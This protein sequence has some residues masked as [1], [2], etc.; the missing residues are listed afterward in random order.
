MNW[1][2][3]DEL[4]SMIDH[5]KHISRHLINDINDSYE[6]FFESCRD[7]ADNISSNIQTYSYTNI[8]PYKSY[9]SGSTLHI[10]EQLIFSLSQV[11]VTKHYKNKLFAEFNQF[12]NIHSLP[13]LLT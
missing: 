12:T 5:I 8:P 1:L 4:V 2:V 9:K 7:Y 11:S 13:R 3:F 10:N 6:N